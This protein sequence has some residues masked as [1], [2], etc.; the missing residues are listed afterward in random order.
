MYDLK[1]FGNELKKLRLSLT[2]KQ[3]DV[4]KLTGVN[5]DTL[6]RL[7][8]GLSIPK[9]ETLDNLSFVYK[10]NLMILFDNYKQTPLHLIE[11]SL[12]E[13]TPLIRK[14]DYAGIREIHRDLLSRFSKDIGKNWISIDKKFNQYF[15]YLSSLSNLHHSFNDKSRNDLAKLFS[16]LN[17]SLD[18]I[19]KEDS[20]IHLDI[21][22]IRI[23]VL[24]SIIY[25]YQDNFEVSERLLRIALRELSNK[26][27]DNH[28]FIYFN[29]LI[30]SNLMTT[31][32]RMDK[33]EEINNQFKQFTLV[34]EEQIGV[35]NIASLFIRVGIN[36]HL[37]QESND[38]SFLKVALTILENANY[39]DVAD[40]YR[41]NFKDLYDFHGI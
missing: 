35:K 2:L 25:R 14:L 21:M 28:D 36:N 39:E 18:K 34:L 31:Y 4:T 19:N 22:E 16:V 1:G 37:I 23:F 13:I 30:T 15:E 29:I 6:R 7:E 8:N 24:L 26:H 3:S 9:I 33:H 10:I 38:T 11:K 32:H 41:K 5:E 27:K 40:R 17:L 12:K 20:S